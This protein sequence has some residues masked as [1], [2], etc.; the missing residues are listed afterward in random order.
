M[1]LPLDSHPTFFLSPPR[2]VGKSNSILLVN[3]SKLKNSY[4][5]VDDDDNDNYSDADVEIQAILTGRN[6]KCNNSFAVYGDTSV[7]NFVN[8]DYTTTNV[9]YNEQ[10]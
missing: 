8:L 5:D 7:L 4:V 3:H 6:E 10:K 9:N 1:S 2:I